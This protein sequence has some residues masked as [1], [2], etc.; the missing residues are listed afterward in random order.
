MVLTHSNR[1]PRVLLYSG[2]PPS[3]IVF[4]Y[5][6]ITLFRLAFQLCSTNNSL[7]YAGPNPFEINFSGLGSFAFAHHYSRNRL[8]TFFSSGYLDVSVP[9]VTLSH[10]I[11]FMC[12]YLIITSGEFPHSEICGSTDVYSFPQLIAVSHVLLRLL[13]PRHSPYALIHLTK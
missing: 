7:N 3:K 9:R 5:E 1:I 2:Y 8:F 4:V 11:L 6:T 12:G 13:V 10:T